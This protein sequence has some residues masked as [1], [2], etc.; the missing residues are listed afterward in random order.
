MPPDPRILPSVEVDRA[1]VELLFEPIT[2]GS[3]LGAITPV[4]GGL[5]NTLFRVTTVDQSTY[6]LRISPCDRDGA[7]DLLGLEREA[8]LLDSVAPFIPVPRPVVWDASGTRSG[9][10]FVIYPWIDGITLNECRREHGAA[11]LAS[12]AEPIGRLVA[13]MRSIPDIDSR[14][15]FRRLSIVEA[16]RDAEDRLTSS[17]ARHRLGAT[18]ADALRATLDDKKSALEALDRERCLVHGDFGGRNIV[19]RAT[20]AGT[21]EIA[22]VLDWEMAAIGS[23]LWDIG[24]LFRYATRYS[25][26]FRAGFGRGYRAAGGSLP[27][28]WW[29]LARLLDVTRVVAILSETRDLST[30]FDDCRSI[31]A[32]VI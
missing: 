15:T 14:G 32:S 31:V 26:E 2:Q 6:A 16:V 5:V 9:L 17:H 10:R 25:T 29:T 23:P 20:R 18:A 12:L 1:T 27:D 22:G 21:W 11:S 24:S 19:V 30:V 28:E 7:L 4:D 8:E 3:A 13:T